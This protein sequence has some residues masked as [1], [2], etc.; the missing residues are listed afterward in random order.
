MSERSARLDIRTTEAAKKM[1]ED[2]ASYLGTT[3]SAFV[4]ETAMEKASI[5][6]QRSKTIELSAEEGKKFAQLLANPPKPNK[7]LK[8][9]FARHQK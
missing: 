9:L 1:I 5:I 6:L 3:T 7:K 4:L 8:Q 2:A